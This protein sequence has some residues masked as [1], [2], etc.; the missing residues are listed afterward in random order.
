MTGLP[1]VAILGVSGSGKTQIAS[2]LAELLETRAVEASTLAELA[3]GRSLSNLLT[4]DVDA[5]MGAL[6]QAARSVLDPDG[7]GREAVVTLGPSAILDSD[8]HRA[9]SKAKEGGTRV[10][11]LRAPLDVLVRRNGL[12]APQPV[13]LGAPRAW[14]RQ[15][16]AQ[17][18]DAYSQVTELWCDTGTT[19][20]AINARLIAG[21]LGL[22]NGRSRHPN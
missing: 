16:M 1:K 20:S 22:T 6:N 18:E 3:T 5:A 15:Q 13:P 21:E 8:V 10:V 17:L 11:A 14:F 4:E 19:D 12:H 9:L 2:A 7:P